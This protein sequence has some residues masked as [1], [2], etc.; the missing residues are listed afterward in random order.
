MS[1]PWQLQLASWESENFSEWQEQSWVKAE[2][3]RHTHTYTPTHTPS[4]THTPSGSWGCTRKSERQR[5]QG[6]RSVGQPAVHQWLSPSDACVEGW[7]DRKQQAITVAQPYA[8]TETADGATKREHTPSCEIW[9]NTALWIFVL[10]CD[11]SQQGFHHNY[12]PS[13]GTPQA[14]SW[15]D[16]VPREFT[17]STPRGD[18]PDPLQA[19]NGQLTQEQPTNEAGI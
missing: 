2:A 5:F 19:I 15:G 18:S 13:S 12:Y 6:K 11:P 8:I 3:S 10:L 14:F 9:P 1:I 4:H 7:A 17:A 16:P